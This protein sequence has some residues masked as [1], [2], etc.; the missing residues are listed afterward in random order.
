MPGVSPKQA[1]DFRWYRMNMNHVAYGAFVAT[2]DLEHKTTVPAN[3]LSVVEN[4]NQTESI[5]KIAWLNSARRDAITFIGGLVLQ[6]YT[7]NDQHLALSL[8]RTNPN[9]SNTQTD[10]SDL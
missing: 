3:L 4:D 7:P 1:E 10:D 6:E 5:V 2:A 8:L 9:W